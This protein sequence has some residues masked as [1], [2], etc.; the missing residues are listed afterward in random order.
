M[1]VYLGRARV[2]T[3]G[4]SDRVNMMVETDMSDSVKM[5][6]ASQWRRAHGL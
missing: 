4:Q 2:F 1:I 3:K 5:E 6:D